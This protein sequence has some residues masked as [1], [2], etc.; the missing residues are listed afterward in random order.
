MH[1]GYILEMIYSRIY[2]Y[3]I[4]TGILQICDEDTLFIGEYTPNGIIP[5]SL[6]PHVWL[7]ECD[8]LP[9]KK[10][11]RVFCKSAVLLQSPVVTVAYRSNIRK[12]FL[13]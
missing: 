7:G 13:S 11:Y 2:I 3:I 4:S 12:Q 8:I 1:G 6:G 5:D 9:M 10:I